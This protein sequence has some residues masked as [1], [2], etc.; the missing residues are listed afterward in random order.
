MTVKDI[1]ALFEEYG[2]GIAS[3]SDLEIILDKMGAAGVVEAQASADYIRSI[4]TTNDFTTTGQLLP[5]GSEAD[6]QSRPMLI[7]SLFNQ[8]VQAGAMDVL[9]TG[10]VIPEESVGVLT[11]SDLMRALIKAGTDFTQID[12]EIPTITLLGQGFTTVKVGD[13]Y[14]DAG[15][16]AQDSTDG[17]ITASIVSG[18][19]VD[20]TIPGLY[21]LTYDVQDAA[22]NAAVQVKRV[23]GVNK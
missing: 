19:T 3:I 11:M 20:T 10:V 15:A 6:I 8:I 14:V 12:K 21:T 2:V 13:T 5:S 4:L 22:G 23:V 9:N 18:G 1:K 7:A 16:T 17:D